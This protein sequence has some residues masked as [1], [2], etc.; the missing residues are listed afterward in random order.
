MTRPVAVIG[1]GLGG[2]VAAARLASRGKP[3]IL[4]ER[5]DRIGGVSGEWQWEGATYVR[6]SV[7]FMGGFYRGLEQIG[8]R[9]PIHPVRSRYYFGTQQL[10]L[11]P[12]LQELPFWAR[13]L[14]GSLAAAFALARS[15][16]GN[17]ADALVGQSEATRQFFGCFLQQGG[18]RFSDVQ[19]AD[20]RGMVGHAR[21]DGLHQ[22][23]LVEGGPQRLV[24]A[25]ADLCR[26]KGV[27]IR[28][29]EEIRG[30][31]PGRVQTRSGPIDVE[32]VLSSR[33]RWQDWTG[34]STPGLALGQVLVWLDEIPPFPDGLDRLY[35][36]P[37][38]VD[39][40]HAALTAGDWPPELGWSLVNP[41][42]GPEP[43]RRTLVGY[44]PVPAGA[45]PAGIL[46]RL[47]AAMERLVPGLNRSIR[48]A[49]L[50]LPPEYRAIHGLDPTPIPSFPTGASRRPSYKNQETGELHMGTSVEPP[51]LYGA[52]VV[53][54]A[55]A[56]AEELP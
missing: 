5:L 28:L 10:S 39:R 8:I 24:D 1:A 26:Q 41:R 54:R 55:L 43:E 36:L 45:D 21:E 27:Q 42:L 7:E 17:L 37:V 52:A 38:D 33:P 11:P 44:L 29:G 32:G 14:P 46:E 47:L 31:E 35:R 34:P 50:L 30:V 13:A 53:R 2:L 20:A 56:I 3:V 12:R 16:D 49:K 22:P 6:G 18:L 25:L 9:M 40:W 51:S 23:A 48:A 15:T 4:L 19:A